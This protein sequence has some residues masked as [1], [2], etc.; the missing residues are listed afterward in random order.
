S[1]GT[2]AQLADLLW[3]HTTRTVTGL[4]FITQRVQVGDDVAGGIGVEL[5]REDI[6]ALAERIAPQL[7]QARAEAQAQMAMMQQAAAQQAAAA[8]RGAAESP[9]ASRRAA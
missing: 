6:D 5:R 8:R 9:P 4:N 3:R 7:A 1:L 2:L